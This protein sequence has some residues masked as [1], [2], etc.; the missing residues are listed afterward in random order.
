[1]G[2]TAVALKPPRPVFRTLKV[3][4]PVAL[5]SRLE[6]TPA[7]LKSM[8]GAGPMPLPPTVKFWVPSGVLS[9]AKLTTA[10]RLPEAAGVKVIWKVVSAPTA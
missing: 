6:L 2:T 10:V 4:L 7:A 9:L 5:A 1:M 3:A 8:S